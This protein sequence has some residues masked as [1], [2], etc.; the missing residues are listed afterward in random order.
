ME[1]RDDIKEEEEYLPILNRSEIY[2]SG[3]VFLV[4]HKL[5]SA[6]L[7]MVNKLHEQ[8]IP[9]VIYRVDNYHSVQGNRGES[10]TENLQLQKNEEKN[11][12]SEVSHISIPNVEI[13]SISSEADLKEVM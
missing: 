2:R 7:V 10:G 13:I 5:D 12:D 9:V 3:M 8:Q 11:I 4:V 6:T 1:C